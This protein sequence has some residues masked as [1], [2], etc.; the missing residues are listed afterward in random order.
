MMKII[1]WISITKLTILGVFLMLIG[2]QQQ[3]KNCT[4]SFKLEDTVQGNVYIYPN[5]LWSDGGDMEKLT[6]KKELVNGKLEIEIPVDSS[7]RSVG[8][9]IKDKYYS[10]ECFAEPANLTIKLVNDKLEVS[11]GKINNEYVVYSK[12]LDTE[13]Y[14][15]LTYEINLSEDD[16][17]FKKEYDKKLFDFQKNNPQSLP[18]AHLFHS[19]FRSVESLELVTKII[20]G[21]DKEI[22]SYRCIKE[23]IKTKDALTMTQ[24]GNVASN[25]SLNAPDGEIVSLYD[26][27]GSVVILDFWASWCGPCRVSIPGM[28]EIYAKYKDKGLEILHISTDAKRED[29]L[30]AVEQEKMPWKQVRDTLDI[31]EKYAIKF[32]PTVYIL[33]KDL[34]IV[35]KR[36]HG[37]EEIENVLKE[38]L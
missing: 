24:I 14:S 4:L 17:N 23:L 16:E 10:L 2:C 5:Y 34:K 11:G 35:A 8:V 12:D 22:H 27:K 13:R 29:W 30:K 19:R 31:S 15:R 28:K 7:F 18:L 36:L 20:N 25:F 38:L 1:N 21:F 26:Y 3:P 33:D 6:I 32:I 37:K 9:K